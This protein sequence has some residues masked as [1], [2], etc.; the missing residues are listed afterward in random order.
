LNAAK[1]LGWRQSV[2]FA[3]IRQ[4]ERKNKNKETP[5]TGSFAVAGVS[6]Q[7]FRTLEI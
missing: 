7:I 4:I 3:T 1:F 5:A 6:Y 2:F